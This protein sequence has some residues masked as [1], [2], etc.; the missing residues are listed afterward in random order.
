MAVVTYVTAISRY[1]LGDPKDNHMHSFNIIVNSVG[2]QTGHLASRI[3]GRY[4]QTYLLHSKK[5]KGRGRHCVSGR[6]Q[7]I[8]GKSVP[9]QGSFVPYAARIGSV[10]AMCV[11][12][13]GPTTDTF[14]L[15]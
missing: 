4:F 11:T 14:V 3:L 10:M 1:Y 7:G 9:N 12:V 8:M 13:T 5:F 2:I 15:R 6:P